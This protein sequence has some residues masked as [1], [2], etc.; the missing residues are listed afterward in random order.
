MNYELIAKAIIHYFACDENH[1]SPSINND[2]TMNQLAHEIISLEK[3][4]S[5]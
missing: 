4:E 3:Q 5:T 2:I 1:F